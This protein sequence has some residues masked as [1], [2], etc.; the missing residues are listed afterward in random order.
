MDLTFILIT[1]AVAAWLATMLL[2][3]LLPLEPRILK[4]TRFLLCPDAD[5]IVE[6]FKATYHRQGE[7]G[8]EVYYIDQNQVRQDVKYRALLV[9]WGMCFF[10]TLPA[11]WFLVKWFQHLPG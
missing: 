8:I 9:F 1:L 3:L 7:F 4:L 2:A 6:K 11:A 5:L 10:I